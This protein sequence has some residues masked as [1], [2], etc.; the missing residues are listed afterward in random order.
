[1]PVCLDTG[2][3]MGHGNLELDPYKLLQPLR[4]V[5]EAREE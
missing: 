4:K 5:S 2:L 3:E 1:M